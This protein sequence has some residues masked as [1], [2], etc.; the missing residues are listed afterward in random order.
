MT[1]VAATNMIYETR[2]KR[3]RKEKKFDRGSGS[4]KG[5]DWVCQSCCRK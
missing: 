1:F 4:F 2:N 5:Y 3:G